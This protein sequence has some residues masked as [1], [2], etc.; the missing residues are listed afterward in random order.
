M[1]RIVNRAVMYFKLFARGGNEVGQ[2]KTREY[3]QKGQGMEHPRKR[4]IETIEEVAKH[5]HVC[6]RNLMRMAC[7]RTN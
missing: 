7:N 6:I 1:G 3:I 4:Y 5:G 2:R